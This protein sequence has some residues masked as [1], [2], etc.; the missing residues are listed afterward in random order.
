MSVC[1]K[2][3]SFGIFFTLWYVWTK[4]K[5]ATLMVQDNVVECARVALPRMKMMF[6]FDWAGEKNS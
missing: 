2:L 3:W 5:L 4:K 6:I 1:Y